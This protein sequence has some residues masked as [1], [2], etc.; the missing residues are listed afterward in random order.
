M[1]NP[2]PS[3]ALDQLLTNVGHLAPLEGY[4]SARLKALKPTEQH[5]NDAK[6]RA[7]N[8]G[9]MLC[10]KNGLGCQGYRIIGSLIKG[11]ANNPVKD[12]DLVVLLDE[13]Y[14]GSKGSRYK[15]A[16]VIGSLTRRLEQTYAPEIEGGHVTVYRQDHSTGVVFTKES[17]VNVDIVPAFLV[18]NK[19]KILEIPERSTKDWVPTAPQNQLTILRRM[20]EGRPALR[21]AIRLLKN[22]RAN[23]SNF[24]LSSFSLEIL[25]QFVVY[26]KTPHTP[27]SIVEAVLRLIVETELTVPVSLVDQRIPDDEVV[28][29]DTGV[30]GNNIARYLDRSDREH[31]VAL[32]AERLTA[33]QQAAKLVEAGKDHGT[34]MR[35]RPFFGHEDS[36]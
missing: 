2:W 17:R 33:L 19:K 10:G 29:M 9:S 28:I 11:T 12:I 15:P 24:P 30:R 3:E 14:W 20:C 5:L 1:P 23:T 7:N 26:H 36:P 34:K 35:L 27:M 25:A 22:W 31:I 18:D 13:S 32:A 16:T 4:A 8:L 6:A 21:R